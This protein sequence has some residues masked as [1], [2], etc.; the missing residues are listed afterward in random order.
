MTPIQKGQVSWP[1]RLVSLALS[2]G[3]S[4]LAVELAFRVF[5]LKQV[6]IKAGIEH[7]HFHHR[8]KPDQDYRFRS[9]EFDVTVHTNRYGLRGPDPAIPKPAG[10]IRILMLGDSFTFGFPVKDDET[11]S[12]LVE[13]Q[14]RSQGYPV[15]VINGGVSGYSPTL[16]YL[17][18]RDEFLR[19]EPDLVVLWYDFGDLQE[20]NWFQKNLIYDGQGRIVRC[21]PAYTHGRFD[22]WGWMKNHSALAKY[23]D[24]KVLR[25]FKK[26][27]ILGLG[28]Y[29]KA[30]LRGERAKVAIARLKAQQHAE[31]LAANDRFLLLRET[32]DRAMLEHYWALSATYLR[33]IRELLAQRDIPL[34]LG[35]YPYGMLVGPEQWGDGRKYW[36]FEKGRTYDAGAAVAMLRGFA[37]QEGVS[38]V[39]TIDSFRAAGA[40][41]T[42]FYNWDGHM[43]PAGHRVLAN[44]LLRDPAFLSLLQHRLTPR[45]EPLS[46]APASP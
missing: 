21:D 31:D 19:F 8:L 34:V 13:Q 2:V 27:Q 41:E 32:S 28:G 44:H 22:R 11:F 33:M 17:S 43:T 12:H 15:E 38:F 7:P 14:L 46:A 18:L 26:I 35:L 24:M 45:A 6:M 20:D 37:S 3:L 23:L 29:L 42:L 40:S 1:V 30:T 9:S 16:H 36:G 5:W 10:V 39:N 25:T 4:L